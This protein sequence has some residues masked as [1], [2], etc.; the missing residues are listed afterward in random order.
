M[1]ERLAKQ[2][3]GAITIETV[4]NAGIEGPKAI[5]LSSAKVHTEYKAV[6]F[7]LTKYPFHLYKDLEGIR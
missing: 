6:D 4:R 3:G 2:C 7:G 5:G 1:I